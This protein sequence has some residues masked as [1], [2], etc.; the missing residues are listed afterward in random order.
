MRL[1]SWWFVAL[2]LLPQLAEPK[3]FQFSLYI[4]IAKNGIII[5]C[6]MGISFFCSDY[7]GP[8]QL[9]DNIDILRVFS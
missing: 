1:G 2:L 7:R 6:L 5:D 8:F 4:G 3:V 9:L